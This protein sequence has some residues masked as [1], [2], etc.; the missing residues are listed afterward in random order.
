MRPFAGGA[1]WRQDAENCRAVAEDHV[2]VL[3]N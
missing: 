1:E 3:S 2:G